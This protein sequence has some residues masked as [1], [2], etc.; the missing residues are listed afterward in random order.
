MYAPV[1][2]KVSNDNYVKEICPVVR[3][4]RY[5]RHVM[6]V[7]DYITED[8]VDSVFDILCLDKSKYTLKVEKLTLTCDH[9]PV[10]EYDKTVMWTG[11]VSVNELTPVTCRLKFH[12]T[13]S[14]IGVYED[15]LVIPSNHV[16]DVTK[17]VTLSENTFVYRRLFLFNGGM[18]HSIHNA[19][20]FDDTDGLKLLKITIA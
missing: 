10:V 18:F 12:M 19:F 8:N 20:G 9:H 6:N 13:P 1:V 11:Y 14:G 3:P 17:W 4:R 15:A 7:I 2:T 5:P 16:K